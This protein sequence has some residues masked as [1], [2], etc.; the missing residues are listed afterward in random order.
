M[1]A[2][3]RISINVGMLL[4]IIAFL[5]FVY[6]LSFNVRCILDVRHVLGVC[7]LIVFLVLGCVPNVHHVPTNVH[8]ASAHQL[9]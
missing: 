8:V 4:V 3:K 5:M 1:V 6:L 7:F 2:N 9:S